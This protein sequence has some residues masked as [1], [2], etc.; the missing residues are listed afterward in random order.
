VESA[1]VLARDLAPGTPVIAAAHTWCGHC[2]SCRRGLDNH[3]R[4]HRGGAGYG[5]DGGLAEYVVVPANTLVELDGL[6]PVTAAPLA[7]AGATAY[8]AVRT[9]RPLLVPGAP[10]VVI[11]VGGLGGYA[12][13]LLRL[14]GAAPIIA[15]D[16]NETRL[17]RALD[18]GADRTV[19]SGPDLDR[20]LHEV[21]DGAVA[22]LD[23]V[24]TEDT[25]VV[26]ASV[27]TAGGAIAI[28]GA[29]GGA[30]PVGWGRLPAGCHVFTCLGNTMADLR[31]VVEL[32][33]QDRLSLPCE[34]IT[35]E[36]VPDA[37]ARLAAGSITGRAVVAM[38]D[39]PR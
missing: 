7:D 15:I 3:C 26:A 34:R 1:G 39:G 30:L 18:L 35:F 28:V 2:S 8:H 36:S 19:R 27:V 4:A 11:G 13:Q 37:Y 25:L 29:A 5:R 6:H 16:T 38:R 14:L 24:G 10:V 31:A 33:R 23:F 12:V 9:I 22:V 20:R 21:V 17:A 32:A